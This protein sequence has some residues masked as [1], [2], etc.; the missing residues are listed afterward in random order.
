MLVRRATDRDA[1]VLAALNQPIQQ[2][3]AEARPDFFKPAQLDEAL[4]Q[5]FREALAQ[6]ENHI[7]IDEV[8]GVPVGYIYAKVVRRPENSFTYSMA[9]VLVDQLSVNP[10]YQGK[11]YGKQLLQAAFDLAHSENIRRVILDVWDFNTH[12]IDFYKDQGFR[13]YN[14]RMEIALE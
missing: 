6:P 10:E 9:W 13:I 14:E 12:A 8:N 4:I 11:G 5:V 1:E 7:F 3:H 2:L